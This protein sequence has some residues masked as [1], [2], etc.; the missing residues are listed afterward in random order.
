MKITYKS[1][2][3]GMVKFKDIMVGKTFY[4]GDGDLCLKTDWAGCDDENYNCVCLSNNKIYSFG[5]DWMVT[6]VEVELIVDGE[7]A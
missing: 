3:P 7:E 4:D 2:K 5:G 6:P 1:K